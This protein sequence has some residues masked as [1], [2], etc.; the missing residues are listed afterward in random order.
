MGVMIRL[1][2][3]RSKIVM[4]GFRNPKTLVTLPHDV[5]DGWSKAHNIAAKLTLNE[6]GQSRKSGENASFS[7]LGLTVLLQQTNSRPSPGRM[8][9][10]CQRVTMSPLRQ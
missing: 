8:K 6:S 3:Q 4:K 2:T 5:Q 9:E 7:I 10:D 1:K